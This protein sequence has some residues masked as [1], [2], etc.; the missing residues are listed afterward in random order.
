MAMTQEQL[1]D[2]LG[3]SAV[4]FVNRVIALRRE[5]I[6]QTRRG[7]IAIRNKPRSAHC[8]AIAM[9]Y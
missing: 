7:F 5:D 4:S 9:T 1:A 6:I 2:M 8:H 3:V